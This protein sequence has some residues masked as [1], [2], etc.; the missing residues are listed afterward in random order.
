MQL[1][2]RE[3]MLRLRYRQKAGRRDGCGRHWLTGMALSR[4]RGVT[5]AC[6]RRS[7]LRGRWCRAGATRGGSSRA[8]AGCGL[9][10]HID[11]GDI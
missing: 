11:G 5:E 8:A 10:K 3:H 9:R 1:R 4:E 7:Q 2:R 6:Q